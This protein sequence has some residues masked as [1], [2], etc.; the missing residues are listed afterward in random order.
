MSRATG[1]ADYRAAVAAEEAA[2]HRADRAASEA[3]E[4]DQA[5][6]AAGVELRAASQRLLSVAKAAE[7]ES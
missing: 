6:H 4:A 7:V 3:D 1:L 2:S 5:L